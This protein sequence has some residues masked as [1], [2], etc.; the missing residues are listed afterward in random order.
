V[1]FIV[2]YQFLT[3]IFSATPL[4]L[5]GA[6]CWFASPLVYLARTKLLIRPMTRDQLG[7][8]V[9]LTLTATITTAVGI[10]LITI[11]LF[12]GETRTGRGNIMGFGSSSI[13]SP[14]N[15]DLH[16]SWI[17]Y[18][19][20]SL[21]MAV[22]FADL[23]IR[24][25]LAIWKQ[26]RSLANTDMANEYNQAMETLS[27][28]VEKGD[29]LKEMQDRRRR[30]NDYDDDEPPSRTLTVDQDDPPPSRRSRPAPPSRGKEELETLPPLEMS[31]E[32]PPKDDGMP[33]PF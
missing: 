28:L 26:E 13:I 32:E 12:V 10:F 1:I 11:F 20:R 21:L 33:K 22:L 30:G 2:I 15:L 6:L 4:L 31:P 27:K 3:G 5:L 19:A 14:F 24:M 29:P 7:S 17:E 8:L 18:V 16:R 23:L 9:T 25:N